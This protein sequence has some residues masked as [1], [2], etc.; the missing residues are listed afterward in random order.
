[1]AKSKKKNDKNDKKNK[2]DKKK[3]QFGIKIK[4]LNKLE[5]REQ[6]TKRSRPPR[7]FFGSN[8]GKNG[9]FGE[10]G[11]SYSPE[12]LIGALEELEK[13]YK[14]ARKS[15]KFLSEL[16]DFLINYAGR[17]SLLSFAPRLTKAWGGAR[18]Y[19]KREDLNHTGSHKINNVIGQGLLARKMGK[20]RLIAE[21]GAGQ[22]G[23]ATATI[24]ARLGFRCTVYM[25]AEDA[26]RQ[27]LNVYRMQMLGAEVIAVSSGNGT[28]KDATNDAMRDWSRTVG[29][30]HY[31][32]GSVIGPHPFPTMVRDF[33]AII[34]HEA[35]KQIRKETG[36]LPAAVIACV[37]GGSNAIGIFHGFLDDHEVDLIGVEAGGRGDAV[38]DNSASITFGGVGYF[39]GARS[40]FIQGDNGQIENVHSVSAGLDYP[41]VGPE[42]AYLA[43]IERA[44]YVRI[45]DEAALDALEE[46]SRLEGIL[47]ALESS[48]ALAC[49][50]ELATELSPKKSIIVSLSG[51]GDKDVAEVAALRGVELNS[52][53]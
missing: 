27:A 29:D 36:K 14:K 35:R 8:Y 51:R 37:G 24:A 33:Q 43:K 47:P 20:S 17:P 10:F 44:R 34:G 3:D 9:Y 52:P 45:G 16:E 38:G 39:H 5:K 31:V 28:L 50:R 30:T 25:G 19:L 13:T 53:D 21:T 11:G 6:K 32:I 4:D 49:A 26:R 1:M 15:G 41:G 42:H 7:S 46:V 40:L 18:I 2:N 48:H 12:V 22:H 23:V